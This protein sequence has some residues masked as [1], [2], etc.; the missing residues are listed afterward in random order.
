MRCPEAKQKCLDFRHFPKVTEIWTN[1]FQT[2]S[3]QK[4]SLQ[5]KLFCKPKSYWVSG[6]WKSILVGLSDTFCNLLQKLTNFSCHVVSVDSKVVLELANRDIFVQIL[7]QLLLTS[8]NLQNLT[9]FYFSKQDEINGYSRMPKS[10]K[11]QNQDAILT[12]KIWISDAN[13]CNCN[14][15]F[16]M[17]SSEIQKLY[18][19][20]RLKCFK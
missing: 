16:F 20:T 2:R 11:R 10:G 17:A 12:F 5:T 3:C 19:W 18:F 9:N 4:L 6:K 13:F 1:V 8:T 7:F 15:V 14:W